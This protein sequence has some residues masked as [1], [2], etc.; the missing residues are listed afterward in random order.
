MF[1]RRVLRVAEN[2]RNPSVG[3]AL[4]TKTTRPVGTL[5]RGRTS[6][7]TRSGTVDSDPTARIRFI[8]FLSKIC[9]FRAEVKAESSVISLV[10]RSHAPPHLQASNVKSNPSPLSLFFPRGSR[11]SEERQE[12]RGCH[13]YPDL[14]VF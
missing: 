6:P 11:G 2:G 7:G 3:R 13:G 1:G 10:H 14:H 8:L 12:G 5:V 9:Q 4:G